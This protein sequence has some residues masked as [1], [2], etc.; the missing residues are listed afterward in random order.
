MIRLP[1]MITVRTPDIVNTVDPTGQTIVRSPVTARILRFPFTAYDSSSAIVETVHPVLPT[2]VGRATIVVVLILFEF[3]VDV[4]PI[5]V[6]R[7][8]ANISRVLI[9]D[10]IARFDAD[11]IDETT[12]LE[13]RTA[14][15]TRSTPVSVKSPIVPLFPLALPKNALL[16]VGHTFGAVS[17]GL[18]GVAP[19]KRVTLLGLFATIRSYVPSDL[20]DWKSP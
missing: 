8:S 10:S 17:P 19:L 2:S 1:V 3:V 4:Y 6:P 5:V 16:R 9:N 20:R 18:Y 7:K 12:A 11:P 14:N 15:L 13:T